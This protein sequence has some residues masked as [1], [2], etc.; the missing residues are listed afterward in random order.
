MPDW[1]YR[2]LSFFLIAFN[3]VGMVL[4]FI[5]AKVTIRQKA[6]AK[7]IEKLADTFSQDLKE[8][9][10]GLSHADHEMDDRLIRVE[11]NLKHLPSNE[12]LAMLTQRIEGVAKEVGKLEGTLDQV[13]NG[14]S[15]IH[16]HLL[17]SNKKS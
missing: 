5:H 1:D 17:N 4:N 16:Q 12:D 15:L 13:N 8:S 6:N 10:R 3:T 2:A 11:E 9:V 14:V 7:S